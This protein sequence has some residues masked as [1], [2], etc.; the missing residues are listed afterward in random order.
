MTQTPSNQGLIPKSAIKFAVTGVGSTLIH[1]AVATILISML[2]SSTQIGNGIAFVL[3]TS[4]SYAVNTLWSFSNTLNRRTALRF[5]I[6]SFGGLI[7]TV[8]ISTAAEMLGLDYRIGIALVVASV[9]I[10]SYLAH[11]LWT[12]R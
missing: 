6:T 4:F 8:L 3:A 10:Y 1:V 11:S 9:P 2:N 5:I 12:Y 7:L